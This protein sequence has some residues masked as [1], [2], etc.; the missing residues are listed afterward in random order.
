MT[1]TDLTRDWADS[2]DRIKS[3]FPMLEDGDMPFLKLD[4]ARFEAHLA[5]R[6]DMTLNEAREEF[7]DFLFIEQLTREARSN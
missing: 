1:W 7:E 6:H 5:E 3:R 2:Y 4:R